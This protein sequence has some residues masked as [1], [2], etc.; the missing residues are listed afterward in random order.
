MGHH[1][2]R[3]VWSEGREGS[4]EDVRKCLGFSIL[5]VI[6]KF[7]Q[8]LQKGWKTT[9]ARLLHHPSWYGSS[10]CGQYPHLGINCDASF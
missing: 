9:G 8:N 1:P 10:Q 7:K 4:I 3:G 2:E 6:L 5:G